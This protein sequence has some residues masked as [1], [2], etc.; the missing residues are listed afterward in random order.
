MLASQS[1]ID[2]MADGNSGPP[3]FWTDYFVHLPSVQKFLRLVLFIVF[4]PLLIS[5]LVLLV[6][7]VT[8]HT[9]PKMAA[10]WVVYGFPALASAFGWRDLSRQYS[11]EDDG[12]AAGAALGLTTL[13]IMAGLAQAAYVQFIADISF[14]RWGFILGLM[15]MGS[16]VAF[17]TSL[18]ATTR[19]PRLF[20][21]LTLASA[22]WMLTLS[23]LFGMAV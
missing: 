17:I 14:D 9:L 1:P 18:F 21:V 5:A 2:A 10:L 6:S 15:L 8:L 13:V 20:S 12:V 22:I 7:N 23:V 11:V 16:L 19:S 3:T 4:F